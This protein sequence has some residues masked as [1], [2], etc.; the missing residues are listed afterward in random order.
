MQEKKLWPY[1][2]LIALGLILM[3]QVPT[4]GENLV[5]SISDLLAGLALVVCGVLSLRQKTW[6]PWAACFVGIYLQLAPLLFWAKTP[7]LYWNDTSI[8]LLVMLFSVILPGTPG[9]REQGTGIPKGWSYNPSS[10]NARIPIGVLA[11]ICWLI[12]RYMAA[13]QLGYIQTMWDPVFE[14]GTYNVITS[15]L[16][17]SFPISDAGLGAAAYSIEML[18]A[19][20]GGVQ[21]FRTMP[22]I[23]FLFG[24]LVVPVGI[25]SILLIM[26]QPLVVGSWCFWCLLTAIAMLVMI[27]LTIDEVY[28]TLQFLSRC[29]KRGLSYSTVFWQGVQSDDQDELELSITHKSVAQEMVQGVSFSYPL[30]LCAVFGIWLLFCPEV[31]HPTPHLAIFDHI[32]GAL[33]MVVSMISMA[34][35]IRNARFLITLFGILIAISPWLFHDTSIYHNLLLGILI[36]LLS[37]PRG[38]I[39]ERYGIT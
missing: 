11:G 24:I 2:A 15:N 9:V 19:F 30:A 36:I 18:M 35:V 23:V 39:R 31:I 12:A 7:F 10:W 17:K 16:S 38:P 34:E 21:R 3:V 13:F 27:A 20:K 14:N 25:V 29:K 28:A 6:A 22:W 26:C 4:F 32:V 5:F 1:G 33:I 8:G 37:I